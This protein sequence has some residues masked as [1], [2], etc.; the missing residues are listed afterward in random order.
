MWSKIDW[1]LRF[2]FEFG[3]HVCIL[4][5]GLGPGFSLEFPALNLS[6]NSVNSLK[7]DTHRAVTICNQGL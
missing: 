6:K 2:S 7:L 3:T 4:L 1:N 5:P